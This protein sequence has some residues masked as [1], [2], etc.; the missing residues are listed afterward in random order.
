MTTDGVS[1]LD[2]EVPAAA[3]DSGIHKDGNTIFAIASRPEAIWIRRNEGH[4]ERWAPTWFRSWMRLGLVSC[5][6]PQGVR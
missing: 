3:R 2:T 5:R 4:V 6:S 1:D